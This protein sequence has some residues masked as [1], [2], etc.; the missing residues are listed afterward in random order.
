M[1]GVAAA[2][3]LR[4]LYSLNPTSQTRLHWVNLTVGNIEPRN[5]HG[6]VSYKGSLYVFGGLAGDPKN[7]EKGDDYLC[8][9]HFATILITKSICSAARQIDLT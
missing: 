1:N 3:N 6:F 4:D 7:G 9:Q 5:G 2:G 8:K